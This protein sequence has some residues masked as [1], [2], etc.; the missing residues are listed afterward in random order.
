MRLRP[1]IISDDYIRNVGAIVEDWHE[2][3][4]IQDGV[5]DDIAD[6]L[7]E[8]KDECEER[9]Y[10]M[11][12]QLQEADSGMILQERIDTLESAIDGLRDGDMNEFLT[13][14]FDNVSDETRA[15]IEDAGDE[16]CYED[17]YAEFFEKGSE[18]AAEWKE[19]TEE[20]IAEFINDKL[21]EIFY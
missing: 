4:E 7:E 13:E 1:L 16:D 10:N 21:S 9:L 17:W 18:A 15:A 19:A 14:G 2:D 20:V 11:P 5:W 6:A 3:Y 8:I 12:E